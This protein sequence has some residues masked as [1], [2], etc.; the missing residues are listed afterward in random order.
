VSN[1]PNL[2]RTVT[3]RRKVAKR[4]YPLYLAP[5]PQNI[6]LPLAPS[7]PTE[8]IPARKKRRV[9]EP[10]PTAT[11]EVAK[12]T[13][14]P[15][16]SEGLPSP[17][18]PPPST[19][20]VDISTCRRSRRQ[21]QLPPIE[22]S[23]AQPDDADDAYTSPDATVNSPTRRRSSRRVIPTS[24]TG[25]PVPPPSTATVDVSTRCRSR[26]QIQLP[27]IE[28]R[29]AQLDDS[30]AFDED[31]LP[32]PF[33]EARLIELADYRKLQGHCNVPKGYSENSKLAN[34][35]SKQRKNYNLHQEGKPSSM[36]LSCI[37]E[38]E[39][40]G[41]EWDCYGAAWEDRLSELAD[42]RKLYLS[43][44]VPKGYSENSKL[45][46]WVS[47]QRRNYRLHQEG[48]KSNMTLSRF[49]KLESLGFEWDNRGFVWDNRGSAWEDRLSE[50]AD[51]RKLYLSCNVPKNYSK[52]TKLANWVNTQRKNYNLHQEGKTSHMTTFRIQALESLGFEWD[53]YGAAWE[54]C[55]S[56]LAD[57][58]KLNGHCNVP[59]NYVENTKLGRW[60]SKQKTQYKLHREGK[61][62]PMS[63]YRIQALERLG[64]E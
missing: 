23:E 32:R 15:D 19:A 37:Q 42:Y 57:Y 52:N 9:E 55:L 33:W 5:P 2:N 28:M 63:T 30:D 49:H 25:T 59:R 50:L 8:E 29:E 16:I 10:L 18:T 54:D 53:C 47:T 3:V 6:A 17:D 13:A 62:S 21:I 4:T 39:S 43:C 38:L 24:S 26:R 7:P 61:T 20:T 41:F 14:S 45:A 64:F 48:K 51:Y 1:G 36:T 56:E 34:W 12:E 22:T 35:V 60:V 58:R 44:N 11:D 27:P 31:D 40:L 46:N